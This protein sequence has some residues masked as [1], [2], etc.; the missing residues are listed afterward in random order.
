MEYRITFAKQ[1]SSQ[2]KSLRKQHGLTQ[3]KL[4][5]RLGISQ[6]RFSTIERSPENVKFE[7]ILKILSELNMD[8]VIRERNNQL[9]E[10][11]KNNN[12]PW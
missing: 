8:L 3:Q 4:A 2:L 9:L 1:L 6:M 10:N 12:E 7:Q 5:D 11:A